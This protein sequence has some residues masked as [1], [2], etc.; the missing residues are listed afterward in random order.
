MTT[1][2]DM[3]RLMALI[4]EGTAVNSA[5]SAA[6][7]ATLRR[8]QDRAMIPRV[9]DG[10]GIEIGNKTGTDE[11]KQARRT[12]ASARSAP[13]PRSSPA[14]TS[15]RHRDLRPAGRGH[16]LGIDNDALR[17]ERE[18]HETIFDAFCRGG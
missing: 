5:A 9:L 15:V 14:R 10:D 8:Q 18:S 16:A 17:P 12:A 1:P 13:T 2:R 3:A 7:L 4:A 6:M 11:E